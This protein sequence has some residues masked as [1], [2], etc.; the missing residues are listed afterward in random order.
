GRADFTPI[1]L[2]WS[3]GF[4]GCSSMCCDLSVKDGHQVLKGT[5]DL[6][7]SWWMKTWRST[8]YPSGIPTDLFSFLPGLG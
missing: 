1:F 7:C 4:T 3:H 2:N 6:D 5:I 8:N